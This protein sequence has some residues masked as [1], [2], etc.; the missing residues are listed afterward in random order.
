MAPDQSSNG[1][2]FLLLV[3]CFAV[4]GLSLLI[5]RSFFSSL[6]KIPGPWLTRISTVSEANALKKNRRAQWVTDLFEQY[7]DA[8]AIRT[9][10]NSVAFN[11]PDAVKEIYGMF[12]SSDIGRDWTEASG[13]RSRQDYRWIWQVILVRCLLNHR[14]VALLDEVEEKTCNE[15]TNGCTWI[16]CTISSSL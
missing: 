1:I 12:V 8:V 14:R 5:Y 7:P 2:L 6:S 15:T 10:P 13:H 4:Y 9:G 11:H 3:V 16:Q